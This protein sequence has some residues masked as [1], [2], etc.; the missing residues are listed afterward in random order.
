MAANT[1]AESNTKPFEEKQGALILAIHLPIKNLT[2]ALPRHQW[3]GFLIFTAKK[4]SWNWSF[5]SAALALEQDII[6]ERV[7]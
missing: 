4:Q 5:Q 2:H 1:W 7:E 3:R 6:S